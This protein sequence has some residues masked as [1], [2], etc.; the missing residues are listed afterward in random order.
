VPD[1]F[2]RVKDGGFYGWPYAYYGANEDPR[3]KG[4]QPELVKQTLVPDMSMG[5]HTASL[6]L[7][8]YNLKAFPQKYHGGAFI[9]QH[10]S[11]NRSELSG[12]KV[13]FV[14]FQH[15][16]PSGD[17]G[18]PVGIAILP[19]GDLLVA[20]DASNIIWKIAAD[21]IVSVTQQH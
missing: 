1:Y 12:Y 10:G 4:Q 20:D 21:S 15:G 18:R 13:V 14:P 6:G 2:T 9:A 5:A 3:L 7:A 17:H 8:F 19:N 16:K 11:W